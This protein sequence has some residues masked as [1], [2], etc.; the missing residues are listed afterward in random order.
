M[1]ET[2][3]RL[4]THQNNIG[5]YRGLLRTRLTEIERQYLERRLSEEQSALEALVSSDRDRAMQPAHESLLHSANSQP[6]II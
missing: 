5:R 1:D 3:A 2:I 6:S 4:R